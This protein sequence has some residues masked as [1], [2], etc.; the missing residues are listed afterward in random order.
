M[1][2]QQPWVEFR[3]PAKMLEQ[4]R[5]SLTQGEPTATKPDSV[6]KQGGRITGQAVAYGAF[7][8]FIALFSVWPSYRLISAG[9]AIVS[10]T[11]SHAGQRIAECRKLTPQ[12][13]QALPPNMRKLTDCPRERHPVEVSFSIDGA[14]T[15]QQSIDPSGIWNDGESTVYQRLVVQSGEHDLYIGLGDSGPGKDFTFE[16]QQ[17][18]NFRPGQHIVVEFDHTRQTFEIR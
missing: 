8:G 14:L 12:E 16:H 6:L 3:K 5:Q 2:W 9:E 4:F 15:Y 13:L 18:V 1:A 7:A 11:F 10:L 17:I